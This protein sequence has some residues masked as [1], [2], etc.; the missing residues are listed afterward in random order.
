VAAVG[1]GV[2]VRGGRAGLPLAV[3]VAG[4]VQGLNRETTD[5]VGMANS[6]TSCVCFSATVEGSHDPDSFAPYRLIQPAIRLLRL[7]LGT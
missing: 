7:Q 6:C 3:S 2:Q 5:A 4:L 1:K